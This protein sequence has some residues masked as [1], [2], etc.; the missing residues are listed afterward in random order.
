MILVRQLRRKA[1]PSFSK[2]LSDG[3]SSR[4]P[5][6]HRR[7]LVSA[8]VAPLSAVELETHERLHRKPPGVVFFTSCYPPSTWCSSLLGSWSRARSICRTG[9]LAGA[10][11]G[12]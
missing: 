1:P 11:P 4:R 9:K 7:K 12:V 8:G 6:L 10:S 2:S 5:F 3:T